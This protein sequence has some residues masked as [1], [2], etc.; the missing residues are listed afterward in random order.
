[1]KA[2]GYT[3]FGG[4]EV[5]RVLQLPEP[6]AR[7]GQVR[8][9]VQ[10][11]AVNPADAAARSG[12]MK[13][14]Y[15]PATL[16]G[17]RYPEPPYVTGW[18]FCGVL[19]EAPGGGPMDV[20]QRVIGLTLSPM[21]KVGAYAEY[22]VA[23]SRSVV[24]APSNAT[25]VAAS[26]LLMNAVTAYAMLEALAVPPGG[27]VAV[28]GAA[29]PWGATR[30]NLPNIKGCKWLPMQPRPMRN[31]SRGWGRTSSSPA[32]TGWPNTFA[33][34]FP[35]EWTVPSTRRS[36]PTPSFPRSETEAQSRR[37]AS[38]SAPVNGPSDGTWCR[39]SSTPHARTCLTHCAI[40]PRT[41]R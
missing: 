14:N 12:W 15:A 30:S 4:P 13:R 40:S 41:A 21:G 31:W 7:P 22:V 28:T 29:G 32:A 27:T 19:D 9:H 35:P 37:P 20:G 5:L 2:I 3:E 6:H 17:G 38:T 36:T 34:R 18:D 25:T 33:T 16:P 8:I 24:R 39:S 10:A 11:A 26:T 1:M 23:D